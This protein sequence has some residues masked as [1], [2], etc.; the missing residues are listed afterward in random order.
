MQSRFAAQAGDADQIVF[1]ART[2]KLTAPEVRRVVTPLLARI[3]QPAPR[4]RRGQPVCARHPCR[5][6]GRHDRVRDG[7]LR[8]AG[9]GAPQGGG[10]PG[11]RHRAIGRS[12]A[13]QVELGGQ[14]IE[15]AQQASL[16]FATAVG[17]LAAIVILLIAFGS[18]VAMGLPIV[19]ALLGLGVGLGADRARAATSSTWPTSRPS[20]RC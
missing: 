11:H 3:A 16:G 18:F 20:S 8:P 12:P 4:D 9:R 7:H 1:R 10:R 5:V 15:Q 14:A 2:G 17:L 13:L 6:E 19:T